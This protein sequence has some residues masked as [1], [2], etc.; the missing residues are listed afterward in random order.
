MP[1]GL[2]TEHEW[3]ADGAPGAGTGAGKDDTAVIQFY[4][5]EKDDDPRFQGFGVVKEVSACGCTFNIGVPV[6]L[7]VRR[8]FQLPTIRSVCIYIYIVFFS[9]LGQIGKNT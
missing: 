9:F 6:H 7:R 5:K 4:S 2:T 8:E 3:Q 1:R